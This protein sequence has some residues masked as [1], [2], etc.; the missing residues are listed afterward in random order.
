MGVAV[1][2]EPGQNRRALRPQRQRARK[3]EWLTS[4][5]LQT[6]WLAAR[7]RLTSLDGRIARVLTDVYRQG[8]GAGDPELKKL[9]LNTTPVVS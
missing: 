5:L 1:G 4:F 3:Y 7:V 6:V 2:S 8:E 9:P